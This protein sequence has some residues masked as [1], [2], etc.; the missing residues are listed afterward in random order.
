M[1]SLVAVVSDRRQV[2][3]TLRCE[4]QQQQQQQVAIRLAENCLCSF[5]NLLPITL[6][7]FRMQT[8]GSSEQQVA[9]PRFV[10]V[11]SRTVIGSRVA[12]NLLPVW[13]ARIQLKGS[14]LGPQLSL[15]RPAPSWPLV[16]CALLLPIGPTGCWLRKPISQPHGESVLMLGPFGPDRA[17][18]SLRASF[19]F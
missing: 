3:W 7:P 8:S 5:G 2:A 11:W 9:E 19:P 1:S 16:E 4:Q 17:R 15:S 18:S 14:R 13:P 6:A 10:P 12:A